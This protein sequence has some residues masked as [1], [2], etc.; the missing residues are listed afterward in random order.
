[1]WKHFC[2]N[3]KLVHFFCICYFYSALQMQHILYHVDGLI[4]NDSYCNCCAIK[5]EVV[6]Y[7]CVMKAIE[8]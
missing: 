4:D 3:F 5:Y 8:K 2:V 7:K 6:Q 1:M